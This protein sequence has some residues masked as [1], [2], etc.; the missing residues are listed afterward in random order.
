MV[1]FS[2]KSKSTSMSK[3]QTEIHHVIPP[4]TF[5]ILR[6]NEHNQ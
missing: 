2:W 4:T 5:K 1:E 6:D 3:S